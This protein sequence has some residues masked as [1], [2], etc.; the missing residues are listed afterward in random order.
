MAIALGTRLLGSLRSSFPGRPGLAIAAYNAGSGSVRRWLGE[1]GSDDF[2]V[3]VER[4]PFDETR[5]YVKRVL[6]SEAAYAY[7]YAPDQLDDVFALA[8]GPVGVDPTVAP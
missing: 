1:R 5:A 2:D 7:L 6:S 8:L 3:F 4:I